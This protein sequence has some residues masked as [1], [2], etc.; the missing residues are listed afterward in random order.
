MNSFILKDIVG[1]H[2]APSPSEATCISVKDVSDNSRGQV[3]YCTSWALAKDAKERRKCTECFKSNIHP[4]DS[5]TRIKAK[6]TCLKKELLDQLMWS[7][8]HAQR[9][10]EYR[11]TLHVTVSR[12]YV[13]GSLVHINDEMFKWSLDPQQKR[14]NFIN[15]QTLAFHQ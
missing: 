2:F 15:V 5:A 10:L 9:D 4:S 12:Q 3:R 14:I 11:E 7:S 1:E 13:K 8:A 6:T